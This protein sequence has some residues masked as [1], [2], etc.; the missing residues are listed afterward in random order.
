MKPSEY[1]AEYG[2]CA[3]CGK[4]HWVYMLEPARVSGMYHGKRVEVGAIVCRTH[5]TLFDPEARERIGRM[6]ARA[7][8]RR[9][10]GASR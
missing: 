4:R 2:D 6:V 5:K 9:G 7:R 1:G 3:A 10:D 8:E